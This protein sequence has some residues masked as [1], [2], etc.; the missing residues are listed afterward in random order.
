MRGRGSLP[1]QDPLPNEAAGDEPQP[2]EKNKSERL[3]PL[4]NI[5]SKM[6]ARNARPFQCPEGLVPLS[7]RIGI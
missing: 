1:L 7:N 5:I 6:E 2:Y 4:S 3:V